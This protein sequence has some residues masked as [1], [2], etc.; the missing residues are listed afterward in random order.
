MRYAFPCSFGGLLALVFITLK[1]LGTLAWSWWWVLLPLYFVPAVLVTI[2]GLTVA[3]FIALDL[4]DLRDNRA[5]AREGG[6]KLRRNP[7][8]AFIPQ[9]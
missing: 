5:A 3:F 4:R 7:R 6:A 1:L 2:F 8:S 9:D